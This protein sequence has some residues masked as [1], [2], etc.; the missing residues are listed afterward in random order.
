L[1]H[2]FPAILIMSIGMTL[3]VAPLTSTVLA[4][5]EKHQ[6]GMASGFNSAVARLGGLIVVAMLGAVLVNSGDALLA[7]FATTLTAMAITAALAGAAA[8]FGL[9][10][11][12][13]RQREP[14]IV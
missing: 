2:A 1:T 4:A 12:W 3:A 14:I 8:L 7:P 5:V 6:T 11:N 10:G 9:R 13:R